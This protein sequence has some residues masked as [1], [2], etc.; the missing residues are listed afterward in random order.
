MEIDNEDV[1]KPVADYFGITGNAPKVIISPLFLISF[2]WMNHEILDIL[3]HLNSIQSKSSNRRN[4][5]YRYLH[6]QGMMMAKNFCL[7]ER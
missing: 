1:G 5:Q 6:L 2:L 3:N 4:F 7:M